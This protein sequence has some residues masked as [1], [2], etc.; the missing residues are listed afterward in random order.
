MNPQSNITSQQHPRRGLWLAA[1][2]IVSSLLAGCS[3]PGD[4]TISSLLH[5]AYVCK[6]TELVEITRTH[7]MPGVYSYVAQY[8][9]Y[10]K[11]K[12]GEEGAAKFY[13]GLFA[14][15]PFSG[16]EEDIEKWLK[17][18]KVQDY[19]GDECTDPALLAIEHMTDKVLVQMADRKEVVLLPVI[20]P[21]AGWS[22]FMPGRRGW[23]MTIRRD[24]LSGEPAVSTPV[25][26]SE[27]MPDAK[28]PA[29][30]ATTKK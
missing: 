10:I 5:K 8:G 26:L 22:E 27:L 19:M 28:A 17:S 3:R 29:K 9:F 20:Q 23:E 12:E 13:K 6:H 11:F 1:L 2:L 25:K 18:E 30:K 15:I 14:E 4:D 21:M 24:T 7:S 16:K